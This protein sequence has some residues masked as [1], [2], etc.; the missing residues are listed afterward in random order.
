MKN[1]NEF[2][3]TKIDQLW[4]NYVVRK[5]ITI[6][7][8]QPSTGKSFLAL[9]LATAI[10][11]GKSISGEK[12]T[13]KNLKTLYLTKEN[14]P[15]TVIKPRLELF[16]YKGNDIFFDDSTFDLTNEDEFRNFIIELSTHQI[17]LIVIDPLQSYLGDRNINNITEVVPYLDALQTVASKLNLAIVIVRHWGKN[18]NQDIQNIGIGT[19]GILG[20]ARSQ[21]NVQRI[22][23]ECNNNQTVCLMKHTKCNYGIQ[24]NDLKYRIDSDGFHWIQIKQEKQYTEKELIDIAVSEIIKEMYEKYEDITINAIIKTAKKDN[25]EVK[26]P[27]VRRMLHSMG[28]I[29]KK[30][31]YQMPSIWVKIRNAG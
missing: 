6:L 24:G 28:F 27:I 29:A 16:K 17:D 21:C 13:V 9:N 25:F 18:T 2:A 14:D 1:M 7:D 30:Q 20:A 5:S 3:A 10:S 31:G 22:I 23:D 19:V 8:G 4:G 11:S 12:S 26:Y 15:N